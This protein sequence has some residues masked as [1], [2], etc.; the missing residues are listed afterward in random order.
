MPPGDAPKPHSKPLL[1]ALGRYR[2]CVVGKQREASQRR[3][4]RPE[5][6]LAESH[7]LPFC[8]RGDVPTSTKRHVFPK[9]VAGRATGYEHVGMGYEL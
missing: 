9:R 8:F 6:Q 4:L 2:Y 5:G 7:L 1:S 3:C